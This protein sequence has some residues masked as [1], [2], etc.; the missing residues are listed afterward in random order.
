VV[1]FL[2]P[3]AKPEPPMARSLTFGNGWQSATSSEIR[4]AHGPATLSYY[5]P[6]PHPLLTRVHL[7]MSGV[8]ERNLRIRVNEETTI[9]RR[10]CGERCEVNLEVALKPGFNRFDLESL[11][12]AVRLSH[13]RGQLRSFA[14]HE[15]TVESN[16]G[17]SQGGGE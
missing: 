4:W 16:G 5:N 17:A 12:P 7:V 11:E 13:E 3:A 6:L 8:G 14:L 2:Q 9:G 10:I 15:A 1:V